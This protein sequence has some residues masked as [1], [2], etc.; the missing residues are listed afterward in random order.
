MGHVKIDDVAALRCD[1][2]Y[3]WGATAA[4]LPD[5]RYVP[6]S[7]TGGHFL[8][9]LPA[10]YAGYLLA[11]NEPDNA[12]QAN[13]DPCEAA[14]RVRILAAKFPKAK[15]IVG[16]PSAYGGKWLVDF[17]AELGDF[18][19]AGWHVHGY[20]EWDATDAD[21]LAWF[22]FARQVTATGEFWVTELADVNPRP[23]PATL[24]LAVKRAKWIDRFAWFASRLARDDWYLPAHWSNPALIGLDG[25][26]TSTG[27]VYSML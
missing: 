7:W 25:A 9:G 14:K 23:M 26:K 11:L 21:V 3:D 2:Y 13:L 4:Y 22:E 16:G 6:M 15:L 19:V 12:G 5:P 10:D 18:R 24:M 20:A 27:D 8:P 1:W 17:C